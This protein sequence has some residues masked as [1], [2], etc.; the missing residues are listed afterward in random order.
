[1][2][3]VT[4]GILEESFFG[5][6]IPV[7]HNVLSSRKLALTTQ[8]ETG[9]QHRIETLPLAARATARASAK[10]LA[11]ADISR[12]LKPAGSSPSMTPSMIRAVTEAD[13]EAVRAFL[14]A[15]VDRDALLR[16]QREN[17]AR[18]HGEQ[19]NEPPRHQVAMPEA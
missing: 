13:L 12:W 9:A 8:S 1:M 3:F 15:H 14:E 17:R 4:C 2:P 19:K 5:N 16:R 11:L 6:I 18:A 10:C 7:R